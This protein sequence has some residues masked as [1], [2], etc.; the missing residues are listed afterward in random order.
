SREIRLAL[1][2]HRKAEDGLHEAADH[3]GVRVRHAGAV[4]LEQCDDDAVEGRDA[5]C[6]DGETQPNEEH[7]LRAI[8]IVDAWATG[9]TVT[10]SMFTWAGRVTTYVTMSA[11]SAAERGF[12]PR[13]TFS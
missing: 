1:N 8:S 13:Y 11:M 6:C 3:T 4:P 9:R 5:E 7:Q 2:L 10:E 12:T